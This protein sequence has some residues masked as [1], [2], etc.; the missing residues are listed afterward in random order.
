MNDFFGFIKKYLT[1]IE[2]GGNFKKPLSWLY[3]IVA[4]VNLI[5]PLVL[6]YGA[7]SNR[8][9]SAGSQVILL[10]IIIWLIIVFA[11]LVS[12]MLWWDRKNKIATYVN[13]E[14]SEFVIIPVFAHII[15]TVGEWFGTWI[16]IVGTL[17][18][19]LVAIFLGPEGAYFM[20]SLGLGIAAGGWLSVIIFPI[21]GFLTIVFARFLSEQF[22]VFAAIANNTKK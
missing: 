13:S 12:F 3:G 7:I 14:K 8:I 15:Q 5:F 1:F 10:F 9:F 17:S 16:A 11:A 6:L 2:N 18:S 21:F 19:L 22:R 20:R 4:V